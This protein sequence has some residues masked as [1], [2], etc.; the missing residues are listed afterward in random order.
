MNLTARSY[1]R[2][3][4]CTCSACSRLP[5][6]ERMFSQCASCWTW[7]CEHCSCD[8]NPRPSKRKLLA[9]AGRVLLTQAAGI[10]WCNHHPLIIED[11][12]GAFMHATGKTAGLLEK[13]EI[14]REFTSDM[15]MSDSTGYLSAQNSVWWTKAK[16]GLPKTTQVGNYTAHIF[17]FEAGGERFTASFFC[18]ALPQ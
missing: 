18:P 16:K 9:E 17:G 1:H 5:V 4:V 12:C 13:A 14:S 8:C 15:L 7:C 2:E 3:L 10:G 6:D 11:D